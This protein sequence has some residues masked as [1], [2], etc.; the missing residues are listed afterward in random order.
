MRARDAKEVITEY[1]K[2]EAEHIAESIMD[3]LRSRGDPEDIYGYDTMASWA[4]DHDFI[5]KDNL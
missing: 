2:D 4:E 1:I 5:H 3:E